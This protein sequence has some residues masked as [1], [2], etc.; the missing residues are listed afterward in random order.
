MQI[1]VF[2][3]VFRGNGSGRNLSVI[4]I[5][6]QKNLSI[7]GTN[8]IMKYVKKEYSNYQCDINNCC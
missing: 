6:L 2:I 3:G 1:S 7:H 8:N 4:E 5:I